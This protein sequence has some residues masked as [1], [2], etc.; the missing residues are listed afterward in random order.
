M[1]FTD[2]S[3]HDWH[4]RTRTVALGQR[5][6]IMGI[7]N[8]TPDSFSDGG[9]FYSPE[10]APERALT[11]A[12]QLL[13]EGADI[14]DLGGESTRPNATPL[15]ADEEQSRVLPAIESILQHK[16]DAILSIDTFHASTARRAIEA[17]AEIVND[18]SGHLWD[19][20]MSATCAQL[21]CGTILMHTRGRP[22]EWPTLPPLAPS[23]VLPLVLTGLAERLEA[24]TAA[25]IPHNK[26]VLDP[27]FGFGKRLDENY[28]LLAHLDE[29]HRFNL[30]ILA[31]AS[32]KGFL[33]HTLA[34]HPP[35]AALLNGV[36]PSIEDRLNA[37]T[38]ANVAAILG[39]AHILR[40][41]DVRPAVEAA[42]IADRILVAKE[43]T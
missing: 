31:G 4:L 19:P 35:L 33:A 29:L 1:P 14:L 24:A 37:T 30:P 26:I 9:L 15:S 39:G 34:Q 32:R 21:G 3:H 10:H 20:E 22:Q 8:V 13:D 6:L 41:H 11:Q 40:V 18:V 43:E 12:I 2:R 28:P 16:P 27:G 23:E 7:L 25:G 38:A 42:T 36:T 17:G 5:T